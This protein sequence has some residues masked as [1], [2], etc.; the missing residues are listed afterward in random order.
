MG[1]EVTTQ[2]YL[3]TE[4]YFA[5]VAGEAQTLKGGGSG[6]AFLK[7]SGDDGDYTYGA[8]NVE[9]EIGSQLVMNPTSFRRG[10]VIWKDNKVVHEIMH[11]ME[12]G[13]PPAE[14]AL[15]NHWGVYAKGEGPVQQQTIEFSTTEEPYVEMIFQANNVSKRNALGTVLKEWGESY[16]LHPKKWPVIEI[17]NHEFDAKVE[18]RKI[19]KMAPVFKI[20]AWISEE[21]MNSMKS[22][23]GTPADY[24]QETGQAAADPV[25]AV[26]AIAAS[27]VAPAKKRG[28]F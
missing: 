5:A 27:P 25:Q 6:K 9:L 16:K 21:E 1:N 8:E 2:K 10:W 24:E 22:G 17:G 13:P 28:R 4:D 14:G 23:D 19:K 26:T 18:G 12:Q 11:N 3:T 7:F 15:P 20:I